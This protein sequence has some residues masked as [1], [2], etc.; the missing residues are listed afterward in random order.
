M[1][2]ESGRTAASCDPVSREIWHSG[3]PTD[4][5]AD[6]SLFFARHAQWIAN[7]RW[8][9]AIIASSYC[10]RVHRTGTAV[11]TVCS[12][13]GPDAA[14]VVAYSVARSH[15]GSASNRLL[16]LQQPQLTDLEMKRHTSRE[17]QHRMHWSHLSDSSRAYMY[18]FLPSVCGLLPRSRRFWNI[19]DCANVLRIEPATVFKPCA[20]LAEMFQL[21]R[22]C[23]CT[24][25]KRL[26]K[27][28][29]RGNEKSNT[30]QRRV[31]CKCFCLTL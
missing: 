5:P 26:W 12:I 3:R 22:I 6:E 7:R 30:K 1:Y 4:R 20:I 27:Y 19:C 28:S 24:A 18:N 11:S 9:A 2:C 14:E 31:F 15:R 16:Q 23:R 21:N 8:L 13:I 10:A 25:N 17:L 29:R